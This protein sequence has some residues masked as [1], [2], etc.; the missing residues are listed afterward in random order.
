[1]MMQ[2]QQPYETTNGLSDGK[3]LC[4]IVAQDESKSRGL[5][6]SSPFDVTMIYHGPNEY[7]YKLLIRAFC[8][9]D[10]A[11]LFPSHESFLANTK[12][13]DKL[14]EGLCWVFSAKT[15]WSRA[16]S[17]C[18]PNNTKGASRDEGVS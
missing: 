4:L 17:H 2:W 6:Q 7:R 11:S 10:V 9:M 12:S 3:Y 15:E 1:M 8:K 14:N 18:T 16:S 5:Q 13:T